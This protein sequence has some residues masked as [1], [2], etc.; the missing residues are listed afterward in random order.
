MLFMLFVIIIATVLQIA[1]FSVFIG[2]YW[3]WFFLK[4]NLTFSLLISG[5]YNVLY[6]F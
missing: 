3:P 1:I 5:I 4:Y 2:E 6:I